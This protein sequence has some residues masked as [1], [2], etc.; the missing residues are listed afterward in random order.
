MG[1]ES[2][3]SIVPTRCPTKCMLPK[4]TTREGSNRK[5]G[6]DPTRSRLRHRSRP[7]QSNVGDEWTNPNRMKI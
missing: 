3:E 6:E 5:G 4:K 1:Q 2:A 7:A